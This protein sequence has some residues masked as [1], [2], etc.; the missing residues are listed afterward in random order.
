MPARSGRVHVSTT[1]R[2]Y[3]GKVYETHL[4]RRTYREGGKVR[5]ETVGNISHLP[6]E[7]VELIREALRG[8]RFVPADE[9]D[10]HILRTRP[11]GHVAAV[12]GTVR[13]L[14]LE[15]LV[16]G[17][18][19]PQRDRVVAM[20]VSR[21]LEP[22]SKLATARR[23]DRTTATSTLGEVLELGDVTA[24]DLYEALDWLGR[25]QWRI[26]KALAER[27]LKEGT[28]LLYDVT[29]TYFEGRSC[30]LAA[31]GHSRDGKK[32]KLQIVLGL[33]CASDGCPVAVEVFPGNTGDP[34]TLSSAIH[35]VRERFG[36]QR[37]VFVG[38]RGLIT[39]ARIEKELKPVEGLEWISALRAP[40]IA[41]LIHNQVI[42]LS[43][44][45]EQDL[46]E[47]TS[48]EYPGERLI[49]CRNPLLA[50]DRA[51]KRMELIACTE[52]ELDKIVRATQRK[53]RPLRGTDK[54]G[55]R[56]GRVLGR[57]KV[58][59]HFT[60]E[61]TDDRFTYRR[62]P[63]R[64]EAEARLDGIYVIR[65]SVSRKTLG[66]DGTVQ[67]YKDLSQIERAFRSLKT[68]DLEVRPIHHRRA[69]RVKAHVFLCLLAYYVLWHMRR[70]L[71]PILFQDPQPAAGRQRRA[72]V[73]AKA[74]R[75]KAAEAKAATGMTQ[76]G[77][78]V[79]DFHSLMDDLATLAENRCTVPGTTRA[80]FNTFTE[81]TP[82]QRRAFQLLGVSHRL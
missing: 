68:I 27:H 34:T 6:P 12:L 17:R 75:S 8:Q 31:L 81:P 32:D 60:Y 82:L 33:L 21:I 71:A 56:V 2:H 78:P 4:L 59:K 24:D 38:D 77:E 70:A 57:Y 36:L 28:L 15:R 72:S 40:A 42:E 18:R 19:S 41:A 43:L 25:R 65:T 79:H 16:S 50:E 44:F 45:D 9:V 55:V 11:H 63:E 37:V 62:N 66:T 30:P 35:K 23:L 67:A 58:G 13:K 76:D 5:N 48:P 14:D 29:S 74:Q 53:Q 80:T 54:I 22:S 49:A 46:F 69:D 52:R 26:E 10:F 61:I 51:R 64:I 7:V 20:I 47:I 39:S 1:R 3:K 73:V